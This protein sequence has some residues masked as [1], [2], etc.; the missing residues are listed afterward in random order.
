M[1]RK[2]SEEPPLV[3]R[4]ASEESRPWSGILQT[5]IC[6]SHGY[7]HREL[8][9]LMDHAQFITEALLNFVSAVFFFGFCDQ[10][11]TIERIFVR[12]ETKSLPVEWAHSTQLSLVIGDMR[13]K[14][15]GRVIAFENLVQSL[16]EII[17]KCDIFSRIPITSLFHLNVL[18]EHSLV[19]YASLIS[20]LSLR[21]TL[22]G[23]KEKTR[24]TTGMPEQYRR[25][26]RP[27]IAKRAKTQTNKL[28]SSNDN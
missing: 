19:L 26:Q 28:Q 22:R 5:I 20:Q 24:N 3:D 12:S 9:L 25:E 2:E 23:V 14:C 11:P 18:A 27:S 4:S 13:K 21:V 6:C 8:S 7:L 10:F 15:C 17:S 16:N 1:N